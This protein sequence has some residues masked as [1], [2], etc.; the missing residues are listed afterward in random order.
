[1]SLSRNTQHNKGKV[2]C[3]GV[4]NR[5]AT[6]TDITFK[7]TDHNFTIEN[8]VTGTNRRGWHI[9]YINPARMTIPQTT[10]NELFYK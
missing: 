2:F 8:A 4:L 9:D 10:Q 7:G 5:K 6:V 3:H 1:V